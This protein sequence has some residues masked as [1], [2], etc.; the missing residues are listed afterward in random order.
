MNYGVICNKIWYYRYSQISD[1]FVILD[2]TFNTGRGSYYSVPQNIVEMSECAP[3]ILVVASI[4][5][6]VRKILH[7]DITRMPL[8]LNA[9]ATGV[10]IDKK[11]YF[12][13]KY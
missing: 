12:F 8:L 13:V 2:Y 7:H 4:S 6:T 11:K 5:K 1:N 10:F 9:K 3:S